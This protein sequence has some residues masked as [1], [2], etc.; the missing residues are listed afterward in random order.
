MPIEFPLVQRCSDDFPTKGAASIEGADPRA[1][2]FRPLAGAGLVQSAWSAAEAA[3]PGLNFMN[4][5]FSNIDASAAL[6]DFSS[7]RPGSPFSAQSS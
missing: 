5:D 3:P 4:L 1:L 6:C 7:A 2:A